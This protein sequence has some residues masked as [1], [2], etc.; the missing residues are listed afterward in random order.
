MFCAKDMA[1]SFLQ[2]KSTAVSDDAFPYKGVFMKKWVLCE[3][4]FSNY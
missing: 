1:T 3:W 2:E 4:I